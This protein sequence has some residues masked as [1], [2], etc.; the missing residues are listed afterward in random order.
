MT[1]TLSTF[2]LDRTPQTA[3]ADPGA[4]RVTL[5]GRGDALAS[6]IAALDRRIAEADPDFGLD[7]FEPDDL[8]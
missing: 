3:L 7:P 2:R 6:Q 1:D 4:D 5:S 8:A